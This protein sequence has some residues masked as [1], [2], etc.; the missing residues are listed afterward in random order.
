MLRQPHALDALDALTREAPDR[1]LIDLDGQVRSYGEVAR[2]VRQLVNGMRSLGLGSNAR[3]AVISRNGPEI[4]LCLLAALRGGPILVPINHRQ[5]PGEMLWQ[6]A[7]ADCQ[8]VIAESPFVDQ[9]HATLPGNLLRFEIGAAREGWQAFD[10]WLSGQSPEPITSTRPVEQTYLQIYTS[11]T[12]GRSKGVLLSEQN[13]L[14]VI[15]AVCKGLDAPLVPGQRVYQGFPLFH[16]GGVFATLWLLSKGL[17]LT[18]MRDFN[19][20][21]VNALI[22]NGRVEYAAMVPAMIQACLGIPPANGLT[23]GLKAVVYG[24]S[25]IAVSVL[26]RARDRYQTEFIQIYG[27][28]ETHSVISALTI[29]D[30][31]NAL[32]GRRPE[33]LCSAGRPLPGSDVRIVDPTSGEVCAVGAVGEIAVRGAQ[34]TSGYWKRADATAEVIRSSFL[35]TGDA[36]YMDEEGYLFIVDRLKD[37]IVSGGE[38]V[39]SKEVEDVLLGCPGIKDAAVIGVPDAV[40]GESVKALIVAADPA[41]TVVD[42]IAHCRS[43]LGGFKVPKSVDFISA[44]PRNGAGKVLK[45]VLREPFWKTVD[46][47][48]S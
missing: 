47:R 42:V 4:L 33:I 20:A 35:H 46:R 43:R 32:D 18:F 2:Q 39:S 5:A 41:P 45:N 17:S 31:R 12:T 28:T 15:D 34:I 22:E 23:R 25:P 8:A 6:I 14:A 29:A 26:Q 30:H 44:I 10:D 37:I 40:W 24:A 1:A 13:G 7:D 36:G 16:V 48:V 21:A 38:N 3:V 9:V 11:G 19:P 27:M